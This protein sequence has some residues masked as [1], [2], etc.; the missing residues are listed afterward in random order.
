MENKIAYLLIAI[1]LLV[2]CDR[3][4]NLVI[5]EAGL[6]KEITSR[7]GK[8]D[9]SAHQFARVNFWINQNFDLNKSALLNTDS[10]LILHKNNSVPYAIY[11][12]NDEIN[13]KQIELSNAQDY[14]V[15]FQIDDPL[16]NTGDTIRIVDNGYF[17][18]E[19]EHISFGEINLIIK[20]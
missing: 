18:C 5:D 6:E 3:A 15:E 17:Y 4:H 7:C 2:Q 8:I 16:P 19:G 13:T 14:R 12:D 1:F 20:K 9:V 10:L 11:K